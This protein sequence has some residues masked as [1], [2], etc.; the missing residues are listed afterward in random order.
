[1]DAGIID[2][3]PAALLVHSG[4]GVDPR[5]C[6][7][8][9]ADGIYGCW[10]DLADCGGLE[11][12]ARAALRRRTQAARVVLS[13]VRPVAD[14]EITPPA[15]VRSTGADGQA[16]LLGVV[17]TRKQPQL[18]LPSPLHERSQARNGG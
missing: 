2:A 17:A 4:D 12:S 8:L 15:C 7:I 10:K 14:A 6:R 16:L 18:R 5:Q 1:M 9:R 11:S 13:A 3:I